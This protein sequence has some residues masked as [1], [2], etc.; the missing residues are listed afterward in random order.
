M[1]GRIERFVVK[2]GRGDVNVLSIFLDK[3]GKIVYIYDDIGKIGRKV[4]RIDE[5]MENSFF[6][7]L[8]NLKIFLDYELW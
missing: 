7:F 8:R 1:R 2:E 6:L 3:K 4:G 5:G